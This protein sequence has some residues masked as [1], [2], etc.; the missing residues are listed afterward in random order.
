[1]L[2]RFQ[3]K[4][5]M[6]LF[7]LLDHI[8]SFIPNTPI[9]LNYIGRVVAP[10]F[11]YLLIDGYFY[12]RDKNN[13]AR[14]LFIAS[15]AMTIGN[16]ILSMLFPKDNQFLNLNDYITIIIFILLLIANTYL[17]WKAS[18]DN[19]NKIL[20][21]GAVLV[22]V[23]IL[24]S[25]ICYNFIVIRN[26]I[27]LS[28]AFSIML[29]NYIGDSRIYVFLIVFLSLFTEASFL[30]PAMIYIFYIY[31]NNKKRLILYYTALSLLFAMG[32]ISYQ[33]L[34]YENIQWMMVFAI[35]FFYLYSGKKG[36]DLRYLF[37]FFY[38]IHIW[39]LFIIGYF[40]GR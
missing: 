25:F 7:M 13:Y 33:G 10:V 20:L 24:L 16:I 15:S 3:L 35:P 9:W 12:T 31:K 34:F 27:F 11:F 4:F 32:N 14:R 2:D 21:H 19:K 6:L 5:L 17:L 29:L 26:N 23:P 40:W 28:M 22:L 1:M 30:G 37:Y 36:R 39:I 18:S 38:P 8:G